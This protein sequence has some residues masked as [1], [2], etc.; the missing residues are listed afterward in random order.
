MEKQADFIFCKNLLN[1]FVAEYLNGDI[2]SLIDFDFE[3]LIHNKKYGCPSRGF[4]C[5]DTNLTRAICFLLWKDVYPQLSLLD[6]GTGKR[7]RGDTLN[8]FNT[9]LGSYI[10][11]LHSSQG[12]IKSDAPRELQILSQKFHNSYHT[13][14]NFILLPNIAETEKK[15]AYTL[16]T[17]RG[18]AY[19]DYFDLFLQKLTLCLVDKTVDF[20]LSTLIERNEFFFSWLSSKGGLTYLKEICWLDDY[21]ASETPKNLFSPYIYCLRKKQEWTDIEKNYYI[22]HVKKYLLCATNIIKKRASKMIT[23]LQTICK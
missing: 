8:T 21:F 9:I 15:Q 5:D 3:N 14:G 20:H 18:I 7:Y 13:I 11:N 2:F 1:D 12:I 17:Y 10:P 19:K 4:D 6:I 22:E 16:N 23:V